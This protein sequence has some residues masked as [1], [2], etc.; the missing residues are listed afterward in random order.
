MDPPAR[1]G[2]GVSLPAHRATTAHLGAAY[3][4]MSDGG[5]GSRGVLI[6]RDLLGGSFSYDPFEL[7]LRGVLTNPN[8]VVGQ[9][10]RW[11]R[12]AGLPSKTPAHG[13]FPPTPT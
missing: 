9:E 13:P 2:P 6:G 8:M 10:E 7:Y 5:L 4:C 3:P 1:A 11:V 12:N